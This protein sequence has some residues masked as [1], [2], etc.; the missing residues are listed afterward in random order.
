[1]NLKSLMTDDAYIDDGAGSR[2]GPFK[3]KFGADELTFFEPHFHAEEGNVVI[4]QL[5]NGKEKR[6]E[7]TGV[8]Y[9]SGLRG[10]PP[11]YIVKIKTS[12]T[13][14][15]PSNTYNINGTNVQV[16]NHNTQHIVSTFQ[17]LITQIESSNF[18]TEQK[19]EAKSKLRALLESPVIAAVLGG[20]AQ[21]LLG[22]LGAAF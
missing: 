10:V 19:Q 6:S 13:M 8:Q 16:G 7:V 5:P 12:A 14:P 9:S 20:A 18:T 11:V 2:T 4:Q 21:G 3:T 17:T 15:A 22:S 1:M